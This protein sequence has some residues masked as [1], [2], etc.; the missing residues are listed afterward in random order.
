MVQYSTLVDDM[1]DF[2]VDC[3]PVEQWKD[4][5]C[6]QLKQWGFNDKATDA[7]FLWGTEGHN[8]NKLHPSDNDLQVPANEILGSFYGEVSYCSDRMSIDRLFR[9]HWLYNLYKMKLQ[10]EATE[11]QQNTSF[12]QMDKQ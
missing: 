1:I 9:C 4:L 11:C 8:W 2:A 3:K 6:R 7:L 10:K 5:F 12:V